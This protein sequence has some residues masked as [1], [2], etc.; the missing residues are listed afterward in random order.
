MRLVLLLL[1]LSSTG[2]SF[3]HCQRWNL[4][5]AMGVTGPTEVKPC[6]DGQAKLPADLLKTYTPD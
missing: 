1:I 6:K 3:E 5:P 4:L 2:C